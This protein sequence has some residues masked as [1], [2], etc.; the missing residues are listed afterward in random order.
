MINID[1][2]HVEQL[3]EACEPYGGG[4]WG[5][6][7][8]SVTS[9]AFIVAAAAVLVGRRGGSGRVPYALIVAAVGVGSVIQ[10]GPNPDWQAFAHDLPMAALLAFVAVDAASDLFGHPRTDTHWGWSTTF[11]GG[12]R[13][14]LSGDPRTAW[15]WVIPTVAMVPAVAIGWL[16]S[17]IV[18]VTLAIVAVG[19]SLWRARVRPA[20][21]R[22]LLTALVILGVG[23]LIGTLTERTSLCQPDSLLQGHAAWHVLAALALWW[24]A[25]AIGAR[26]R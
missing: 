1:A 11:A 22:T 4:F 20:L 18:Q 7:A 2:S 9:L 14:A 17:V 15:W 10:H 5:Q 6:P 3:A 12:W 23:A 26:H 21:R 8:S 13:R 24:L 19:L 25:P 16:A